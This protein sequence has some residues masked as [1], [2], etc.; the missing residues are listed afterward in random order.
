MRKRRFVEYYCHEGYRQFN[1]YNLFCYLF[2]IYALNSYKKGR[3]FGPAFF[4][5]S[6]NYKAVLIS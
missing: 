1:G 2:N 4:C 6:L 5:L 3:A